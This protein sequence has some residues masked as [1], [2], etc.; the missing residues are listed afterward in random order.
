MVLL[1]N[2]AML[3]QTNHYHL[4]GNVKELTLFTMNL[5]ITPSQSTNNMLLRNVRNGRIMQL[6]KQYASYIIA[7][8]TNSKL[9]TFCL[10]KIL[11]LSSP[12]L[13]CACFVGTPVCVLHAG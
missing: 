6:L 4:D 2:K 13:V 5:W 12:L 10:F 7:S 11:M 3:P 1:K 9:S 8:Y